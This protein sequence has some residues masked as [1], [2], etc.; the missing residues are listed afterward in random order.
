MS[1]ASMAI[2]G[3][4]MKPTISEELFLKHAYNRFYDLYEEIMD[5]EFLYRDDWYR[6]S[7]V[8]A[9]FAVYAELLSYEPLKHVLELMK[10]QRPPMESEIG[11]Q[12]F[13][14]IRNLLAHF[15]LFERWD[16]VWINQ[17][18]ANWQRS[19][20]TI[21]RFLAK[22]SKAAPVKYRFWEPDKQKM[23]Y[24]T[25]NFPISYG[26]EKIYLKDILAEKDGVKFSLIM[27]RKILNTQVESVG[28]KA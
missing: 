10:T 20:L 22:Y 26:H 6:F 18:M 2:T 7:K 5:D 12:L 17:P 27:M 8:S 14:F 15:P 9:A 4:Q 24:I 16:D 3:K 13:K 21:D 11:G 28:E 25:I 1:Y 23:T 19:G